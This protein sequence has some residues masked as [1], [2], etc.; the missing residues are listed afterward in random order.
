MR[1][2]CS[3]IPVFA[4]DNSLLLRFS[5][6]WGNVWYWPSVTDDNEFRTIAGFFEA[7]SSE[8][9]LERSI[10]FS[11]RVPLEV[12][13]FYEEVVQVP[14][15]E[16]AAYHFRVVDLSHAA[17]SI[18]SGEFVAHSGRRHQWIAIREVDEGRAGQFVIQ[19]EVAAIWRQVRSLA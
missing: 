6:D 8:F 12:R 13:E 15:A 2:R 5:P 14:L 16:L 3:W 1:T 4:R 17:R 9:D 11:G 19:P 7:V 18:P 10:F